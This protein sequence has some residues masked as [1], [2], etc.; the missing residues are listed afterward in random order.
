M[1]YDKALLKQ[2]RDN[3]K[4][5][6]FQP[7]PLGTPIRG[8]EY[9]GAVMKKVYGPEDWRYKTHKD[10]RVFISISMEGD[11]IPFGWT[12]HC[13]RFEP[14]LSTVED[15]EYLALFV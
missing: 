10:G 11:E 6:D 4:A 2:Y 1:T 5:L 12:Y 3:D 8:I 15:K 14:L 7:W 13:W 9:Q